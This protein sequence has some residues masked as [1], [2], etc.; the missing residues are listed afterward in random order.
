MER[1]KGK[2][3]WALSRLTDALRFDREKER[4]G[5][6]SEKQKEEGRDATKER[7]RVN[8]REEQVSQETR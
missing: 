5:E 6:E 3:D 2:P 1:A 8:K 7:D 4:E